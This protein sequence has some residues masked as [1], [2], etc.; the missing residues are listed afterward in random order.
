MA[1]FKAGEIK[2]EEYLKALGERIQKLRKEKTGLSAENFS[3]KI[4]ISRPLYRSYEKGAN[5]T[6][7]TFVKILNGLGVT[8][9]EFFSEGF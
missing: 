4:E 7:K 8:A 6:S 9:E 1:K 5:L 2:E 3:I